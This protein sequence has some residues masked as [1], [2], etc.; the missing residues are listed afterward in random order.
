MNK[1]IYVPPGPD[2]LDKD[3]KRFAKQL[4]SR[5]ITEKDPIVLASWVHTEIARLSPFIDANGRLARIMMNAMLVRA[6]LDPVVFDDDKRYSEVV[7]ESN[8]RP[9]AFTE[10]LRKHAIPWTEAQKASL[11]SARDESSMFAMLLEHALRNR[12]S[13]VA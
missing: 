8:E 3:M 6:G 1:V 9:E 10:F 12:T 11:R 7:N 4:K 13:S 5:I 2:R